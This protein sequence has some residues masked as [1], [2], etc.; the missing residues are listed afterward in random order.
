MF[1]SPLVNLYSGLLRLLSGSVV[2]VSLLIV[3]PIV[4]FCICSLFCCS[5]LC[6]ISSFTIILVGKRG[7]LALPC[8]SSCCLVIVIVLW[9]F[10]TVPWV[11]VQ[12]VIV[13][14]P[15]HTHLGD[16]CIQHFLWEGISQMEILNMVNPILILYCAS[17]FIMTPVFAN[18]SLMMILIEK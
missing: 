1:A 5:L 11:G 15:D 18:Y 8:L 12:C 9:L 17:R 13:V 2:V 3:D 4:G 14:F 6:V 16:N 10:L 7:L